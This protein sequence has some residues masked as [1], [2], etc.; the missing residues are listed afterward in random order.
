MGVIK[1]SVCSFEVPLNKKL[2]GIRKEYHT[3]RSPKLGSNPAYLIEDKQRR[4]LILS[5]KLALLREHINS[6][7]A[8][9]HT[10]RVSITGLHQILSSN[11]KLTG[12]F[13]KYRFRVHEFTL[14][15]AAK[16]FESLRHEHEKSVIVGS[17]SCYYVTEV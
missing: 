8:A 16:E 12:G 11:G 10:E 14:E 1:D 7:V 3:R 2:T 4:Q 17:P 9:D 5:Q 15:E 6:Q 13:T